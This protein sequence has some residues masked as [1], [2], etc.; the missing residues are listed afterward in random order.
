MRSSKLVL[1]SIA[2]SCIAMLGVALYLQLVE[3]M[4]PCPLCV[5]QRYAFALIAF[6]CLLAAS[7]PTGARRIGM[8]LGLIPA[9]SGIAVAGYH[10]HVLANPE[11]SCG[12]D[13]LETALNKFFIANW[14]PALFRADGLCETPYPPIFGLSIPAWAMFGFVASTIALVILLATYKKPSMFGNSR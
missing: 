5:M 8:G 7:L 1:I 9:L 11:M 2:I 14:L 4:L 13:P 12:V 3:H 6:F 10:L